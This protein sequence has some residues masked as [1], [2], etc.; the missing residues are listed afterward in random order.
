[1]LDICDD[2]RTIFL[3]NQLNKSQIQS[4]IP[5]NKNS[6]DTYQD[7]DNTDYSENIENN[8]DQ[9]ES[10]KL[11]RTIPLNDR[12]HSKKGGIFLSP[13]VANKIMLPIFQY[14]IQLLIHLQP[15]S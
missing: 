12:A 13:Y 8:E 10:K 7:V 4:L 5:V 11:G 1:M 9:S 2:I 3:K 14:Y 15:L 6:S